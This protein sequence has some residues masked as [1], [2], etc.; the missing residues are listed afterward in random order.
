MY[1]I[2]FY[3]LDPKPRLWHQLAKI[4]CRHDKVRTTHLI[5]TKHGSVIAV[6][7]VVTWLYLGE[8]LLETVILGNFFFLNLDVFFQGRT[9]FWP[10]LRNDWS[11]WCDMKI[12]SIGWLL[13]IICD[14]SP[15]PLTLDVSRSDFE[16]NC[17]SGIVG[18]I[19]VK[20]K[21]S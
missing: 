16:N 8:L 19:D 6:A 2:T 4:A 20:W 17:I 5:T 12:K 11:D 14:S 18:L 10:Y 9:L 21:G 13:G 3:D 1:W 15:M 7:M